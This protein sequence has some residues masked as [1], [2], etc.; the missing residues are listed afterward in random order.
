MYQHPLVLV[1]K[2]L[3]CFVVYEVRY[4]LL[5]CKGKFLTIRQQSQLATFLPTP[6]SQ[7]LLSPIMTDTTKYGTMEAQDLLPEII[8]PEIG[9][10]YEYEYEQRVS[11]NEEV[12]FEAGELFESY[13]PVVMYV[14]AAL[15]VCLARPYRDF[16]SVMAKFP[17]GTAVTVIG[18][19]DGY[20]KIFWSHHEGWVKK[21]DLTP[22][23]MKVWPHF[24][25]GT[26]YEADDESLKKLRLLI[27]D[28]FATSDLYLPLQA[29]EWVTYRFREQNRHIPWPVTH[30]RV[31]GDWLTLLKGV[32]GIHIGIM[33]K[34]DSIM[35][36]RGEDGIGRVAYVEKVTPGHVITI[37]VAGFTEPGMFEERVIAEAQWR[38]MRPV[39]I[40]VL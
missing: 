6:T 18:Y 38:E 16:D 5:L 37:S 34:T 4:W 35:E 10:E 8:W 12:F 24:T 30:G 29:G 7:L 21:D 2:D 20:A 22:Y 3:W 27:E 1:I 28:T 31:P 32:F 17:Y 36:W 25:S 9:S 33:P 15:A 40:E 23:K 14:S 11:D 39:F 19:Q 13:D 26:G